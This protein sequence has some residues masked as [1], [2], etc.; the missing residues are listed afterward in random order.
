MSTSLEVYQGLECD[1]VFQVI[2][3]DGSPSLG[4]YTADTVLHAMVWVQDTATIVI[5][6]VVQWYTG[7]TPPQTGYDQGQIS[8]LMAAEQTILLRPMNPYYL[9]VVETTNGIS[10]P[11]IYS[12]LTVVGMPPLPF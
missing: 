3:Y 11:V 5:Q 4:V 9:L 10:A 8:I 1:R 2:N 6:P 7:K 12:R